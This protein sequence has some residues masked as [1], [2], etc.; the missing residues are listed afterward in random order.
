M[1]RRWREG[2][3]L[4]HAGLDE[5]AFLIRGLLAL[6]ENGG[7]SR[8]LAWA[9]TIAQIL[10]QQ[11]KVLGGAFYQ[12]DG[13]DPNLI[14]RRCQYADGAEPSGNAVHGENLLKLYQLTGDRNYLSQ[15]EDIL[16]AV[17]KFMDN[18]PP[19]YCYHVMNLQRYY[20]S[21]APL[22][23]IALNEKDEHRAEIIRLLASHFIP[24]KGVV[25]YH[26]GDHLLEQLI[27]DII[28]QPPQNGRTTMYICYQGVCKE[29]LTQFDQM[30]HAI[31]NINSR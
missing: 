29:P 2:E 17:K 4:H 30:E 1:L 16:R 14:L 23:V 12:T 28:K 26:P 7:G 24:H 21:H 22:I 9:M 31:Q 3:G 11:F 25:F 13:T 10:E 20:D 8:W 6:F 27:P 19:G 5:N 15:A 18:Y